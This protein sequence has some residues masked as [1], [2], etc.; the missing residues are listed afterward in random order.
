MEMT[1]ASRNQPSHCTFRVRCSLTFQHQEHIVRN[2]ARGGFTE[3]RI[4]ILQPFEPELV[5]ASVGKRRNLGSSSPILV[6]GPFGAAFS[7]GGKRLFCG[8]RQRDRL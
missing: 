3:S 4:H 1:G 7:L 5:N 2:V 6:Q 8:L